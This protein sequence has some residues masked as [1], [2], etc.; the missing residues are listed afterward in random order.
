MPQDD[1]SRLPSVIH[2]LRPAA[3]GMAVHVRRLAQGLTG[4]GVPCR[5]A[6]DQATLTAVNAPGLPQI[7]LEP[8]PG[9]ACFGTVPPDLVAASRDADILHAHGLRA[10]LPALRCARRSGIQVVL[11]LHNVPG[12]TS[13]AEMLV[14]R[15]LARR[16]C[17]VIA[18]S[19]AIARTLRSPGRVRVVVNGVPI[20]EC[21]DLP[22]LREISRQ[23]LGVGPD[24]PLAIAAGRLA[25]EKGFDILLRAWAEVKS[26]IP[27]A[28]LRIIGAGPEHGRLRR[29]GQS[30][31]ADAHAILAG[32][33]PEASLLLSG[34]DVVVAPSRSEGQGL[35]ILEAMASGVAVAASRTGGLVASVETPRSGLLFEPGSTRSLQEALLRLLT[36]AALRRRLAC[37]G[38]AAAEASYSVER[39]AHDTALLYAEV[40]SLGRQT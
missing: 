22:K 3:G 30:L 39:M 37:N 21:D 25:R 38:R 19:D 31:G 14:A 13:G 18:V 36:D 28:E 23:Q 1:A 33:V 40:Q 8:F 35:T 27:A 9:N 17:R 24:V 7:L 5:L 12:S 10:A 32:P 26:R 34:A 4:I 20:P 6:A 29:L 16:C 15:T 11:T 2:L